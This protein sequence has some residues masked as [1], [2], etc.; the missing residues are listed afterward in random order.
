VRLAFR[1]CLVLLTLIGVFGA[2]QRLYVLHTRLTGPIEQRF[3]LTAI[4]VRNVEAL[5]I[6]N[7]ATPGTARRAELDA[8]VNRLGNRWTQPWYAAMHLVPGILLLLLMPVQLSRRVRTRWIQYHRWAGRSILILGVGTVVS[9]V[10]Y[11][12]IDPQVAVIEAPTIAVFTTLFVLF[13][14]RGY[15]AIRRKAV[16]EHREWMIRL[17]AVTIAIATVRLV[18]IPLAYTFRGGDDGIML[19]TSFWIGWLLTLG[20]AEWWIR[21]TRGSTTEPATVQ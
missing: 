13:A 3:A 7:G 18:S 12:I 4:E 8:F 5:S 16:S 14:S 19:I 15:A 1:A 21:R 10:W 9:S 11:G 17:Y 2:S 20:V 6:L